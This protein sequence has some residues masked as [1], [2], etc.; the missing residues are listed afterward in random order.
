MVT[1]PPWPVSIYYYYYYYSS[2]YLTETE[3]EVDVDEK[4]PIFCKVKWKKPS[5]SLGIGRLQEMIMYTT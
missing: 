3:E 1:L 2:K 4:S 5:R